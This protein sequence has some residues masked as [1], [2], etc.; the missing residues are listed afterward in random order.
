[1]AVSLT[2]MYAPQNNGPHT[3]L[4]ETI[5]A[6]QTD[7]TVVDASVLPDAPNLLT[8]GTG[9]DAELV[10]MSA[11]TG[12]IITVTRRYNGTAAKSWETD[13]W[14]YRAITAQ[15]VSALQ[16]NVNAINTGKVDAES[17]KGLSTNDYTTSEKDKLAGI[18]AG[19]NNYVHPSAHP[20]S[21]I[22]AGTLAG[23]VKADATAVAA[24]DVAQVR[25]IRAGTADL[26]PGESALATGEVYLVYE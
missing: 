17:G 20:A 18:E 7:I 1:M 15:D 9:E 21:M 19:A 25:S 14:V 5:N 16:A 2:T 24:L 8:I 13:E 3:A 26:T 12:N 6:A 23:Q 11:K 4:A 22:A 10:L